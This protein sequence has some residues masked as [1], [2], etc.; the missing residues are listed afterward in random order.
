MLDHHP[1]RNGGVLKH[2]RC[3][4]SR[5][6]VDL[7]PNSTYEMIEVWEDVAPPRGDAP[8]KLY[9]DAHNLDVVRKQ[10]PARVKIDY[11]TRVFID[12]GQ[13]LF[14]DNF[15]VL[16]ENLA[17]LEGI[18]ESGVTVNY[19]HP[20]GGTLAHFA[21]ERGD[22]RA[23]ELLARRKFDLN[24]AR[25]DGCTPLII[26]VAK[27][28][29]E[30]AVALLACGA[31]ADSQSADGTTALHLG[32][33]TKWSASDSLR[34]I[35]GK[36]PG[37]LKKLVE[38]GADVNAKT[39]KGWTPLH[40]AAERGDE[41][42][43]EMLLEAGADID[44]QVLRGKHAG[45]TPLHVAFEHVHHMATWAL[46]NN[47]ASFEIACAKGRNALYYAVEARVFYNPINS[48]LRK[49]IDVNNPANK[50]A[51]YFAFRKEDFFDVSKKLRTLKA[52]GME[53]NCGFSSN[54]LNFMAHGFSIGPDEAGVADVL[55]GAIRK[56]LF[57]IVEKLVVEYGADVNQRHL[58]ELVVCYGNTPRRPAFL[59]HET[60]PMHV[61]CRYASSK[62][63]KFLLKHGAD[64]SAGCGPDGF[65]TPMAAAVDAGS[66]GVVELLLSK[67]IVVHH[68][69]DLLRA[70]LRIRSCSVMGL[71]LQNGCTID[72]AE[73]KAMAHVILK[74]C[75]SCVWILM[76]YGASFHY[77][78]IDLDRE[79]DDDWKPWTSSPYLS[80]GFLKDL[81]SF[82]FEDLDD[83][84]ETAVAELLR[85][86]ELEPEIEGAPKRRI[87]GEAWEEEDPQYTK[88]ELGK[89]ILQHLVKLR[90]A[91]KAVGDVLEEFGEFL[92]IDAFEKKCKMELEAMKTEKIA[93]TTISV[94]DILMRP[95]DWLARLLRSK[96][97]R[98][99]LNR[100]KLKKKFPEYRSIIESRIRQGEWKYTFFMKGL[101]GFNWLA[102]RLPALPYDMKTRIVDML[103]R[104][105]LIN[106]DL[107][108]NFKK[109]Q[110]EE[111]HGYGY[112]WSDPEL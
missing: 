31:R 39:K 97:M 35:D 73:E 34:R 108:F 57:P 45:M 58:F 9:V 75:S 88:D 42:L 104:Q 61:A 96:N 30:A 99:I 21:A 13:V 23:I 43:I 78:D 103:D 67:G 66:S 7:D 37:L 65:F 50:A 84:A 55:Y 22:E 72:W 5:E 70:A 110:S 6:E 19:R 85:K 10:L 111:E 36:W 29:L 102:V 33:Q 105:D 41:K 90:A 77:R 69:P 91:G 17:V 100:L 27:K 86:S 26:A 48:I 1:R 89:I 94:H 53:Q 15:N 11:R 76:M 20:K 112:D 93:D 63:V 109:P 56:G 24:A 25:D 14:L 60:T 101:K 59:D 12:Q 32:I 38:E 71:L 47:N 64:P 68:R 4:S 18:L 62:I 16:N 83:S 54:V 52:L 107:C 49:G 82:G 95:E 74:S 28:N 51:F 81:L 80:R 98:R 87:C 46:I 40:A 2:L 3:I 106:L 44:P 8:R 92:N 79:L